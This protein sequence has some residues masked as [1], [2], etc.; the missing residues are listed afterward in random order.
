M[1]YASLAGLLASSSFPSSAYVMMSSFD[2]FSKQKFF[3]KQ[4]LTYSCMLPFVRNDL[5][6]WFAL[7]LSRLCNKMQFL[8]CEKHKKKK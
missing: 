5:R 4:F 2:D 6:R 1:S 3:S 8:L 7:R